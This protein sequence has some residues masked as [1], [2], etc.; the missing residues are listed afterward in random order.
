MFF[1]LELIRLWRLGLLVLQLLHFSRGVPP[2]LCE[3]S[4]DELHISVC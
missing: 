2:L 4:V 1:L 3:F